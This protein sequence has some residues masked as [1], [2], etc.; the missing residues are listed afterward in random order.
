MKTVFFLILLAVCNFVF[1]TDY[2]VQNGGNDQALGTSEDKAW[3]TLGKVNSVFASLKPGDKIL[4]R[5]GDTFYGSL[6]ITKSGMAGS[7][8]TIGAYGTGE[9]PEITGFITI[10]SWTSEGNGIYSTTVS[11]EDQTNMV[12]IDGVQ[13]GMGRW[14]DNEYNIFESASSNVSIT[15][16][17]LTETNDWT[18]AEV[19]IRKN[20]WSLDRCNISDH[21]GNKII[22]TSLGT[23]QIATPNHGYFIQDDL[24]TLNEFGEWYH[25]LSSGK[26]YVHFG[27]SSPSGKTIKVAT[28]NS[29]IYL[30]GYHYITIDDIHVT[31]SI[32]NLLSCQINVNNYLTIKNSRID[33]AGEY[34]I[35]LVGNNVFIQNNIIAD[36]NQ[37]AIRTVGKNENIISNVIRNV[38]IIPG[39]AFVGTQTSGILLTDDNCIVRYNTIENISYCGIGLSSVIKIVT[40][41]NNFI[42]NVLM[43]LNDGGGIY[44][45]SA[46]ISRII[47]GNIILNAKG[48]IA[49][50]PHKGIYI[51]RGIYLDVGST[52]T[53]ITNNTVANCNEAGFMIHRAQQNK[54]ENNISYN[55]KYALLL[56]NASVGNIRNIELMNNIFF[57]KAPS[58]ILIRFTSGIDDLLLFGTSDKNYFARPAND[59]KVFYTN[60]PS[61][62]SNYRNLEGW[63]DFTGQDLNSMKSPVAL[64]DTADIDFYYNA[65]TS[66]KVISLSKPMIDV[67]GNKYKNSLTL[68]P[69][70]SVIL[71]PDPN[72]NQSVI[73]VYSISVIEDSNPDAVVIYYNNDLSNVSPPVSSFTV[74]VNGINRKI[75]SV[76]ISG[77][78]V[79]LA[80]ESKIVYGDIVTIVYTKPATNPLQTPYGGQAA[81]ISAQA[82]KNNCSGPANKPPHISISSATKGTL[83]TSPAT[84]IIDIEASDPDG[85]ISK[86]EL[87]NGNN[88]IG[89]MISAPYSYTLKNL[90][91]GNYSI[92]AVATDNLNSTSSS[93]TL[94][95]Q[96]IAYNTDQE[97]INLYPNPNNGC[98]SIDFNSSTEFQLGNYSIVIVNLSGKT[99]YQENLE[100]VTDARQLYLSHLDPG[101]YIVMI[102]S[103]LIIV[104]QKFIKT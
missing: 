86:I 17:E 64:T 75:I 39:Q 33:F 23:T 1:A 2:Y 25:D 54:M 20:D 95:F 61:S 100:Y 71:M 8:I 93:P 5:R 6:I 102:K 63:Q 104:T 47:D 37:S 42:N 36:C 31:G 82:V 34:G 38:G 69:Y 32:K 24:R 66:N 79:N 19:V 9:K 68:L 91:E 41:Q 15:D 55:N 30:K 73:P 27:T 83:L 52:N 49:G 40:I 13:Y 22:Y 51:A 29:V 78:K 12:L 59:D 90:T 96:V 60:S 58:Q 7:P 14:P 28:L 46:G 72:P 35:H 81:S 44:I 21:T 76:S 80:L 11:S 16:N 45:T 10:N 56:Q 62:G 97:I 88:K 43:T 74:E 103:D 99:V 84:F 87:Y 70:T 77:N 89:E 65:S 26:L 3:A 4:F 50:T 94:D 53:T 98:F 18:G 85:S 48:N 101:T 57:A 67:K 92:T